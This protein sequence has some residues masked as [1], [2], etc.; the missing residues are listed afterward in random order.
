MKVSEF[1][2]GS[3][4]QLIVEAIKSAE[5]NTSGEI[6]LHVENRCKKDVLDKAVEVFYQLGMEKTELRN[7]VLFFV[8][9]ADRKFAIIGDQGIDD[10]VPDDFWDQIK[11]NLSA[12]FKQ[13]RYAEGLADAIKEAGVQLKKHFP[14]QSDDVNELSDDISYGD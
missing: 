6:R 7:G 11:S 4:E 5:L 8:A 2:T 13:D 10:K 1:L 3:D 9:V 14:Y 12:A